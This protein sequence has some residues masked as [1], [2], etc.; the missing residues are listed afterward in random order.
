MLEEEKASLEFVETSI[1]L[2]ASGKRLAATMD[3]FGFYLAKNEGKKVRYVYSTACVHADYQDATLAC[4]MWHC[5]DRSSDLGYIQKQHMSVSA[6]G[7]FY[8]R[9]LRVKTSEEQGLTLIPN[10]SDFLTCPLHALAVALATQDAPF[11]AL[12]A[13]L[14][15]P[16][17]EVAA[18]LDEGALLQE[19]LGAEPASLDVAVVP[20]EPPP[21]TVESS[22]PS[23]LEPSNAPA[24][25]PPEICPDTQETPPTQ[26]EARTGETKCG[27]DSVQAYVNRMFKRVA[28]PA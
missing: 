4:L 22:L 5:F 7:T 14:P 27:E 18:P 3:R 1:L 12:L 10:K 24:V 9:L 17:A 25:P 28:D 11:A 16:V 26:A 20:T 23:T 19:L 2:D 6:D 8:L 15:D 13:Q 21:E